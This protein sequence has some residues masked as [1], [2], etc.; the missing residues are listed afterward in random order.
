M[1]R[2]RKPKA[3][4]V[5]GTPRSWRRKWRKPS[6]PRKVSNIWIAGLE[7]KEQKKYI[8]SMKAFIS[9]S[10]VDEEYL[11]RLHVHLA[12][13]RR[14]G[15]IT[16]WYDREILA[17]GDIDAEIQ[18][19]FENSDIFIGLISPDFLNSDYCV[20]TEMENAIRRHREG[21]MTVVS[22]IV[23]PCDWKTFGF[24]K[25]KV[26]PEDGKPI[27]EWKNQNIA[28]LNVIEEIRKISRLKIGSDKVNSDLVETTRSPV[29]SEPSSSRYRPKKHFD[30]IDKDTFRD[31]AFAE[32]KSF[33][34]TSIDEFNSVD[35]LKGRMS[36]DGP[37][38][39]VSVVNK[40]VANGDA[41]LRVRKGDI[42]GLGVGHISFVT[43]KNSGRNT[44]NGGFQIESDDYELFLTPQLFGAFGHVEERFSPEEAARYLWAELMTRAQVDYVGDG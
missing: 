38:F 4:E 41:F 2:R 37:E 16:E 5:W 29:A 27:S 21:S 35:G 20:E 22:I 23:E 34:A 3:P 15:E 28:F 6:P 43:N 25:L 8:E 17:G 36:D 11:D 7:H 32:I 39:D 33:F 19:N 31:R 26:L 10:H 12:G 24:S 42:L 30:Q 40:S 1:Q 44:S 14:A 18:E 9:Y 13:M